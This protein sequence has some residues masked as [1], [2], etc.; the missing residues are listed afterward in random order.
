M[1]PPETADCRESARIRP[2]ELVEQQ[3]CAVRTVNF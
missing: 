1:P 3:R 2:I